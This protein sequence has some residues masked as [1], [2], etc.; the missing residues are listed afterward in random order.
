MIDL[1][2]FAAYIFYLCICTCTSTFVCLNSQYNLG[3]KQHPC[4]ALKQP[5]F[6]AFVVCWPMSAY[7]AFL[8]TGCRCFDAIDPYCVRNIL[9][10]HIK[11]LLHV[12][13]KKE[14]L[15]IQTTQCLRALMCCNKVKLYHY[16]PKTS[17]K[18]NDNIFHINV[19]SH[20]LWQISNAWQHSD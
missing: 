4:P 20:I 7:T 17:T 9:T 8:S 18:C 3:I 19:R 6:L 5:H 16:H 13:C 14:L 15:C 2:V 12:A 10:W 11:Q 1:L